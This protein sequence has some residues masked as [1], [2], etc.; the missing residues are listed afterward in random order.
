MKV[1]YSV[2][3]NQGQGVTIFFIAEEF[4]STTL[5]LADPYSLSTSSMLQLPGTK[6]ETTC[7]SGSR[8]FS[9]TFSG[10]FG[11]V[12]HCDDLSVSFNILGVLGDELSTL[13][14]LMPLGDVRLIGEVLYGAA[15]SFR[16]CAL[17]ICG[18]LGV[19]VTLVVFNS[20]GV[21]GVSC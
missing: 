8:S 20:L 10:V 19:V 9:S 6:V 11:G 18:V 16:L 2:T 13:I 5:F 3:M 17:G 4:L 12:I 14:L 21:V 15:L 7:C 1:Q